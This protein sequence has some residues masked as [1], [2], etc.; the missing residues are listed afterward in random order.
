MTGERHLLR[1]TTERYSFYFAYKIDTLSLNAEPRVMYL[2]LYYILSWH[3]HITSTASKANRMLGFLKRN[4]KDCLASVHK[5]LH[6]TSSQLSSMR[7][8]YATLTS[9]TFKT[10]LKK[11]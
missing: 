3:T 8:A 1:L 2:G 6:Q 10:K 11:K 7:D 5:T 4:F 9:D